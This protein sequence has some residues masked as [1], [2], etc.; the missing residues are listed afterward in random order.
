MTVSEGLSNQLPCGNDVDGRKENATDK[1][2]Q[3]LATSCNTVSL[4][5]IRL[6]SVYQPDTV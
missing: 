1:S 5:S 2:I 3:Q 4:P 6:L